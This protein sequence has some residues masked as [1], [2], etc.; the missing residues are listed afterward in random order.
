MTKVD[1]TAPVW[2]IGLLLGVL[3][4]GGAS[5]GFVVAEQDTGDST[6]VGPNQTVV[7]E[8]EALYQKNGLSKARSG[9]EGTVTFEDCSGDTCTVDI[10]IED[11]NDFHML[12]ATLYA[13]GETL[14]S[15]Y[16]HPGTEQIRYENVTTNAT[17]RLAVPVQDNG[18]YW[19]RHTYSLQFQAD[20]NPDVTEHEIEVLVVYSIINEEYFFDDP[21]AEN[22][23]AGGADDD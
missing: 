17:L 18:R 9:P 20:S 3:V 19:W 12:S 14:A 21:A 7:N 4:A 5:A 23:D 11:F 1:I 15:D 8:S 6:T 2:L 13:D 22:S 16:L 10:R